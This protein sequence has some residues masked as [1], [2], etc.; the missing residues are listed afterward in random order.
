VLAAATAAFAA[1]SPFKSTPGETNVAVFGDAPYG[2]TP[3][4]HA[5]FDASPAFINSINADPTV[6][7]VI[8]V[9]DIH[10]GKQ[11][12]TKDYD[13][14]IY[15]LWKQFASALIYTP[16][17]NEWTDCH[18]FGEGGGTYNK[19]TT[20]IDYV[21]DAFGNPVDYQ[22][23]D[24]IANLA[25]VRSI[26]FANPGHALAD[27]KAVLSQAQVVDADSPS[28][29]K[30]VEN[31]MWEQ[32]QVLFVT[33][34]VPGGSNNDKD[35]W[36]GTP[37]ESAAQTT[38]RNERTAADIHWLDAA[39]ARAKADGMK[40]VV[41]VNQADMWD[42]DGKASSHL[43]GF[44]DIIKDIAT[45]VDSFGKPVL[46]FNGDSHL[47]RSDN[48]LMQKSAANDCTAEPLSGQPLAA[49]AEDDWAHHP[50]IQGF[51][52]GLNLS[53]FHRVV[54]HGSTF[55]L[56][57]LKLDVNPRANAA[58]SLNAIG[59]FSWARETQ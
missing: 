28:D 17:D 6:S 31:V 26:F 37:T 34:N 4:D 12:C 7:L 9:G 53:K 57:W 14:S 2:T 39:F 21:L 44:D 59:P 13:Q 45:N 19:V 38:E 40:A 55:P 27:N 1:I 51:L 36:Y 58:A 10:S 30:Y 22:K 8:H 33:V 18:K 23:G 3:T 52:S 5:E 32:S 16:G 54:V 20:Q 43:T 11:Y 49:C 42:L 50:A 48:P 24:P 46:M 35:I 25:L 41:I 15:E 56:E 29:A 47:Y